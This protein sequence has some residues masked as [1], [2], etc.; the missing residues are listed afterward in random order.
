MTIESEEED[1][2]HSALLSSNLQ[3][4]LKI[5]EKHGIAKPKLVGACASGAYHNDSPFEFCIALE[6][7][8]PVIC[9]TIA[10]ELKSLLGKSV[11]IV[12]Q[13]A[14]EVHLPQDALNDCFELANY[15]NGPFVPNELDVDMDW[16][17]SQYCEA[18]KAQEADQQVVRVFALHDTEPEKLEQT[19]RLML[20]DFQQ[21]PQIRVYETPD[22][23]FALEGSHRLRASFE[24]VNETGDFIYNPTLVTYAATESIPHDLV[25]LPSEI[26]KVE[27]IMAIHN[28]GLYYEFSGD[29]AIYEHLESN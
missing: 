20:E 21:G 3:Q 19:K 28:S 14:P 5:F 8:N 25:N 6:E 29:I 13:N 11:Q 26:T 4:V 12:D 16:R 24:L 17:H 23:Y 9:A 22:A 1:H 10:E 2:G 7:P 18:L 15:L 27:E